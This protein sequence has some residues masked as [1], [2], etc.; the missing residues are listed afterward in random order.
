MQAGDAAQA[1]ALVAMNLSTG[2]LGPRLL[3][4]T[5]RNAVK[6]QFYRDFWG[7]LSPDEFAHPK[8]LERLPLLSRS[9]YSRNYMN[10]EPHPEGLLIS[11]SSGSSGRDLVW[12]YRT[13]EEQRLIALLFASGAP[14]TSTIAIALRYGQHGME[15]QIPTRGLVIPGSSWTKNG[16]DQCVELLRTGHNIGGN[17]IFPT[18]L[19]GQA[20]DVT[21]LAES[22]IEFGIREDLKIATVYVAGDLRGP[23]WAAIYEAFPR[24]AVTQKYSLSEV[25][26]GAQRGSPRQPYRLDPFVI[27]EVVGPDG[28][29][30]GQGEA[31]E[32][33]LTE[34]F[35][36]VQHQPLI[37][38]RT[39]DVVVRESED[40]SESLLF[41]NVSRVR[42]GGHRQP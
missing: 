14:S 40:G 38:Y 29:S 31:G 41:S 30:V 18:S 25:F 9:E 26:G 12:R 2:P 39:G 37:R 20:D 34:L 36:F 15:M 28:R 19:S 1:R 3:S 24:A 13:K 35:P 16:R 33:V 22:V 5:I 42:A 10:S 23:D 4:A 27:G 7:S 11:H 32:L 8:D 6:K 17:V 21:R